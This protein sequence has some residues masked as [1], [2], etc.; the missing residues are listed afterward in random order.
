MT[1]LIIETGEGITTANS[2]AT[3]DEFKQYFK[4]LGATES[5]SSSRIALG[6]IQATRYLDTRWG[7]F[8]PS[9]P[10]TLEQ[11]LEFPRA[12][13]KDRYGRSLDP[14]PRDVVTSTILYA[15]EWVSGTLF[16][17]SPSD[18]ANN[19]SSTSSD[20]EVRRQSV[21]VGPI[22]RTTEYF[23][24]SDSSS[25][26]QASGSV[27]GGFVTIPLPDSLMK[28]FIKATGGQTG[29]SANGRV[30]RN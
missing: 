23:D 16:P 29:G 27:V 11:S 18:D 25:T 30:I 5:P 21:T 8:I 2:Y 22:T 3:V 9:Q 6:L 13:L 12:V 14:L 1:D 28:N 17:S 26:D 7:C 10:L 20:K 4:D 24:N 15:K 19:S